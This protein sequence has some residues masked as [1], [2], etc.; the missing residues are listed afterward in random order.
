MA[1]ERTWI[2]ETGT[3]AWGSSSVETLI[4]LPIASIGAGETVGHVIARTVLVAAIT[5][6]GLPGI[7]QNAW[8][9]IRLDD[10]GSNNDPRDANV[11]PEAWMLWAYQTAVTRQMQPGIIGSFALL[12]QA[13]DVYEGETRGQRRNEPTGASNLL[14][15]SAIPALPPSG[16]NIQI[17]WSVRA[18]VFSGPP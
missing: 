14:I 9:G 4:Q 17:H 2:Y 18:L 10:F 6:D 5:G 15:C 11:N 1:R 3:A 7:V 12:N 16:L 13:V 8:V